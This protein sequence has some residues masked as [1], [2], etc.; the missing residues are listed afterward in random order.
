HNFL[1]IAHKCLITGHTQNEGDSMHSCI[2]REKNGVLRSGPKYLP[3]QWIPVIRLAKK[4][5]KPFIVQ[6]LDTSDV[7]D[8]KQLSE[9]LGNNLVET[10]QKRRSY[11][12]K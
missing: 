2:E 8:L 12:I 6:E 1:S 3:C 9:D 7:Y 11:G 5:G 10:L 4:N